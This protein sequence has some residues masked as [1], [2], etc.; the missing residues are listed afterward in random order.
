MFRREKIVLTIIWAPSCSVCPP[1][2]PAFLPL[3]NPPFRT[4]AL[5]AMILKKV[6][7]AELYLV[8]KVLFLSKWRGCI[9]LVFESARVCA[10][11]CTLLLRE[12]CF[13]PIWQRRRENC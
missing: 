9:P 8:R 6:F 11:P 3:W 13:S 2:L 7:F 5:F 12:S 4:C 1:Q 10:F